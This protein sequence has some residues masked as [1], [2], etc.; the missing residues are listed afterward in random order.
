MDGANP[1]IVGAKALGIHLMTLTILEPWRCPPP[2]PLM[3]F[4]VLAGAGHS[5][6][7]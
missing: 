5:S 1:S 6:T 4:D 2:L 7:R 3:R